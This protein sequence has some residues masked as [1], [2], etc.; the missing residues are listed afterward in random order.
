MSVQITTAFVEQYKSNVFHL[1]QQKGSKLRDAVRT[2]SVTGKSHFFERIGSTAAVKRTSRHA[3]TPRVDTPHS[4]RKVTMDDY[5]WADLIDDSD[6]I[7][8]LISPQSEY[9]KAGAYAMGRTMDDVI[10]AAAT[11]NAFGGVSG[12]STIAL[13][14]GQKIAHGSTGLTIAKLI[15]AKEKLDAAN[16]DPDEARTIVCSAKQISDLLGTTQITSADFNSVKALVQGDIDTFM[17]FKFIRS[18]RLGTDSNGNRQVLAFT[19]TSMGLALGKDI[20]TKIS[21]RADKNYST[22]VYLCMTIGATRVEDE[23][24][25][26]IACTE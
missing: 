17:G 11:G 25:I 26:E 5:D 8:L 23:K 13:P 21:E 3:D 20:Q 6:K 10:I 19:N 12:G 2:E 9:A 16:V 15:T 7:R 4:R 22:Q 24:V 1:A 14:A 18:E